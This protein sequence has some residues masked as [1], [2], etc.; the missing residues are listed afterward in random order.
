MIQSVKNHLNPKHG[1]FL[2][3]TPNLSGLGARFMKERWCGYRDDHLSL[4]TMREWE[5]TMEESGFIKVYSGSTFFSGIPLMRR[6][7]LDVINWFA[8]Y[9]FKS[10]PWSLGESYV[11][12][13][14]IDSRNP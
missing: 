12:L 6:F 13:Y 11:G 8:L 7:P 1:S 9:V 4:R 14:K 3:T 10:L 5:N 2:F